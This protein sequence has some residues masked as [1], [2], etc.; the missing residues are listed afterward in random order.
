MRNP[1]EIGTKRF[2]S[3]A[4]GK[5]LIVALTVGALAVFAAACG[6]SSDSSD[7]GGDS[8]GA[9]TEAASEGSTDLT[10]FEEKV[11]Q[12][13]AERS[14]KQ[15]RTPPETGPKAAPG[16]SAYIVACSQAL[17]GCQRES[18][19]AEEAGEAMGW[20]MTLFD[21]ESKPDKMVEGIQRA[22]DNK[23]DGIIVQAIDMSALAAPLEKAKAAGAAV[24]CFACVNHNDIASQVIP[25][26][27][28]FYED[29]YDIAAQMYKNTEGSPRILVI[30]NKETGVIVKRLEGTKQFVEDCQAAGGDCEIVNEEY[31]LYSNMT[32]AI[33]ELVS[34]SL[35]QHPDTNAV[36][37]GFDSS[38]EFVE[39]GVNQAGKSSADLALY[40]FDGNKANI[41][42]IRE[43]GLQ[44]ASMAGP[45]EWVGWAEVD[46]LNRVFQG[47]EP[48][49]E[50]V[51]SKLITEEN[52]PES[53]IYDGEVDFEKGYLDVWGVK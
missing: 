43:G 38:S 29:G 40:G 45:F 30:S 5:L 13:V 24:V 46:A 34:V 19:T 7:T 3:R 44:V 41:A 9:S 4:V 35:Q 51:V 21:T 27:E 42:A 25:S 6:S 16:K 49:D 17:E 2:A 50:V 8:S 11:D 52:A 31:F 39:Q 28:S 22:I 53:D 33:P 15:T 18:V 23:A 47:E 14:G 48:V 10:A 32:T 36:W 26:E 1:E 12:I 20:N 37:M